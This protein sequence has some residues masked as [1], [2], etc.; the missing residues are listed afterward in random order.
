MRNFRS[1]RHKA[2][3][4]PGPPTRSSRTA[5]AAGF[6]CR[7][8]DGKT[9]APGRQSVGKTYGKGLRGAGAGAKSEGR[10]RKVTEARAA[11]MREKVKGL[12][13]LRDARL[14]R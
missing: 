4:P 5:P 1:L 2:A 7:N 8:G 3:Q 6:R 9:S 13:A 11:A 10:A 12:K 14:G